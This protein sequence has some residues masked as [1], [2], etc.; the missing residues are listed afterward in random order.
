MWTQKKK[1]NLYIIIDFIYS[2][3]WMD[4]IKSNPRIVSKRPRQ[5]TTT[6]HGCAPI[7]FKVS[8]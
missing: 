6:Q 2:Y 5:T 4:S 3:R 1:S 7:W 8:M